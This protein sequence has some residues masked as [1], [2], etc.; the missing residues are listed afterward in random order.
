VASLENELDSQ[1][2]KIQ[3]SIAMTIDELTDT[4]TDTIISAGQKVLGFKKFK[5]KKLNS[6]PGWNSAY[7]KAH[8]EK[9]QA[10]NK[11]KRNPSTENRIELN[12]KLTKLRETIIQEK[13][14]RRTYLIEAKFKK[15]TFIRD[16]WR[17][18]QAFVGKKKTRKECPILLRNGIPITSTQEKFNVFLDQFT[19]QAP[20]IAGHYQKTHSA[21]YNIPFEPF[22]ASEAIQQ[23]GRLKSRAMG[24]AL[25]HNQMLRD[26]SPKTVDIIT[27]LFNNSAA[28]STVPK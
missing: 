12:K 23:T 27:A 21:K 15:S 28:I 24:P 5:E 1:L 22:T 18:L 20:E 8:T 19:E 7:Q 10:E 4:I 14:A 26:L 11:V 25:I 17:N 3:D 13:T 9:K 6:I 16:L 2:N